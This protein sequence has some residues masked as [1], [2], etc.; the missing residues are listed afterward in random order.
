MNRYILIRRLRWPALLLLIGIVA[1][2]HET[3]AIPYFWRVVW[4][5]L[6]IMFGVLLVERAALAAAEGDAQFPG[7]PW[8]QTP[9]GVAPSSQQPADTSIVPSE[10]RDFEDHRS[11]AQS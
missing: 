2:L 10:P 1:L 7:E 6:L 11:G 4:P 5:L 9:Q 3:G 8:Q